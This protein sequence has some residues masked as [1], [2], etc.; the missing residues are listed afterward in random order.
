MNE[1][2]RPIALLA[3]VALVLVACGG[4][5]ATTAAPGGGAATASP[6][7]AATSEAATKP[8]AGGGTAAGV[9]ELVTADEL[10][11]IFG[12]PSVTTTVFVG[13]AGHVLCR[14]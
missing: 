7:E 3:T 11:G 1:L 12:V 9:C 8:P 2:R 14:E 10:A 6:T 4:G 5:G 13:S